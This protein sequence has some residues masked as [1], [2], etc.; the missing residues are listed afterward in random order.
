[1][2]AQPH[3]PVLLNDTITLLDLHENDQVIDCTIGFGGHSQEILKKLGKNGGLLGIDRDPTA[4]NASQQLFSHDSRVKVINDTFSNSAEICKAQNFQPNKILADFGYSSYQLDQPERGFS[5]MNDAPL[6]MRMNP[7]KGKTAADI[8]NQYSKEQLID[9]F[10]NYSD[11]YG[12]DKLCDAII[13]YRQKVPIKRSDELVELIKQSFYFNNSRKRYMKCNSQ[14]FQALRIEV[15]NEF[16][17]IH[18]LLNFAI[19]TL[20]P[21]GRLVVITFHSLEDKCVKYFWKDHKE[22]LQRL[23]KHVIVANHDEIHFNSRSKSAK[24][25]GYER[26]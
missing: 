8:I 7:N 10:K 18:A 5:F 2:S 4:A 9:L 24:L 1:M 12:T 20:P 17:E 6:D 23:N 13:A 25:R 3:I 14:V 26:A 22:S 19:N 15:N 21:G 11:L 16:E